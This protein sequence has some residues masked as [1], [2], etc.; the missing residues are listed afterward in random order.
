VKFNDGSDSITA[1]K[2]TLW[3]LIICCRIFALDKARSDSIGVVDSLPP[4]VVTGKAFSMTT[5]SLQSAQELK[6]AVPGGFTVKNVD[7]FEKGRSANFQDLLENTPGVYTQNGG[8][9]EASKVSIRGSGIQSDDEPIGVEFLLDGLPFNQGDGEINLEDFDVHSLQY[10]EIYR[11]ANAFKYGPYTLG[12]AVNLVPQ[13]GLT[14]PPFGFRL[15]GGSFGALG[16]DLSM[17]DSTGPLDWYVSA[18]DNYRDKSREHSREN[19]G[20]VFTDQ[21]W[22]SGNIEDRMYLLFVNLKRQV[23]GGLTKEEMSNDPA[24]ADPDAIVQDFLKQFQVFRIADKLS[25]RG[26]NFRLDCGGILTA[27]NLKS[28]SFYS[29]EDPE[30][31]ITTR[32]YDAA[33]VLNISDSA[34]QFGHRAELIAGTSVAYEKEQQTNFQNI[35]GNPGD[36]TASF[37]DYSFNLPLFAQDQFYLTRRFSVVMGAQA[38]FAHRRF[39]DDFTG[40]QPQALDYWTLNPKLGAIYEWR[41]V[42]QAFFNISRS[43]QPPSFDNL[44]SLGSDSSATKPVR[45]EFSPLVPQSAWTTEVG[46]RNQA[47]MFDGEISFYR[48]W[49]RNEL[50]EINDAHGNDIGTTNVPKS[51]HQGIEVELD[52][53]FLNA[54]VDHDDKK[55][56]QS[57]L[58]LVQTYTLND[59]HFDDDQVYRNNR[60]A[61]IPEHFYQA[62]L[63]YTAKQ[64]WYAGPNVL[65]SIAPYPVDQTGTLFADPYVLIGFTIG[66]R[67]EKGLSIFLDA[68]NLGNARYAAGVNPIPDARMVS[69]E[70]LRVFYPGDRINFSAGVEWRF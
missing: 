47:G 28:S 63:L 60:I 39:F 16:A 12:G 69:A 70:D 33:L 17:A 61:G 58:V 64:G 46:T 51:I 15:V 30:G 32:Q 54:H 11:G 5:P 55:I 26:E 40:A 2:R 50:L 8:N 20:R 23:P 9:D 19:V 66:L 52:V 53:D 59:F 3:L 22:R 21:G 24:Q 38:V 56:G 37:S 4:M 7:R 41:K 44:I 10:A 14:A 34:R 43:W 48:S 25:W 13:T 62:D 31:I 27:R 68:H 1:M 57:S 45:L 35:Q 29:P 67:T 49:L 6:N 36:S 18:S 42:N 65:W